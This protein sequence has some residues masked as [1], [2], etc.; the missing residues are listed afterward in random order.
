MSLVRGHHRE[1]DGPAAGHGFSQ[2]GADGLIIRGMGLKF[3]RPT[4]RKMAGYAPGEQPAPGTR[5]I[6]LNTN[7]NPFAPSPKVMEAIKAV[8]GEHLRRYPDPMAKNFCAAAAQVLGVDPEM[9]ITGN[10]SDDVLAFALMTFCAPGDVLAYPDPTYSLYPVLADIDGVNVAPVPWLE[11]WQLPV[12]GLLETRAS[13][14]FLANPNAPSGT[15][16]KPEEIE[17]LAR[18]FDGLVLVDEAYADFADGN[19]IDLVRRNENVVVSRTLSK[20][21]SLAGLRFGFAIGQKHVIAEMNKA[22]DSYPCDALS[23]AAATAALLDQDYAR[24]TWDH[25]KRE[26]VRMTQELTKLGWCVIP[27]QTN[28]LF[29]SVPSGDGKS[30]YEYLKSKG[31]LVRYFDKP[32]QRDKVRISLGTTEQNDTVLS[33]LHAMLPAAQ[34]R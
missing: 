32:G 13:A 19:C 21:Y 33:E 18:R 26:R 34:S 10:G 31:I 15:C 4:I 14:I 20:A 30:V 22:K 7:E 6:K 8:P 1:N 28:F 29:A 23:I 25:I 27:S 3:V 11:G 24:K 5:I 16:V 17:S 12:E 9:V 2:I